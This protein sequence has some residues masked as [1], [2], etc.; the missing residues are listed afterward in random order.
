MEHFR[1][2]NGRNGVNMVRHSK[3]LAQHCTTGQHIPLFSS[4]CR[5][6]KIHAKQNIHNRNGTFACIVS[7]SLV[8]SLLWS[9]TFMSLLFASAILSF[10]LVRKCWRQYDLL[11]E[12]CFR[13]FVLFS[14]FSC[15]TKCDKIENQASSCWVV[16]LIHVRVCYCW[17]LSSIKML[18]I[19]MSCHR[20]NFQLF[21]MCCHEQRRVF[22]WKKLQIRQT[23]TI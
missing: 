7:I 14:L 20:W 11:T 17:Y 18:C 9:F 2:S 16:C 15:L 3:L 5:P 8:N 22:I 4:L 23:F 21:R 12:N 10:N 19:V 6:R 13:F 1:S